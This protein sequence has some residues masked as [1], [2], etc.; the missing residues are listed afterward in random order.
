MNKGMNKITNKQTSEIG[1]T[2]KKN[3]IFCGYFIYK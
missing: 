2:I 3:E 1:K